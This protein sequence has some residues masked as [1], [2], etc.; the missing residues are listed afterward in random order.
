MFVQFSDKVK[1]TRLNL[2]HLDSLD[3]IVAL[4]IY[5]VTL[6]PKGTRMTTLYEAVFHSFVIM[7]NFRGFLTFKSRNPKLEDS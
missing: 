2:D 5:Q 1:L 3:Q 7:V 6:K 4:D